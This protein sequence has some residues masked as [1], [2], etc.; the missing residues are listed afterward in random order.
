[1]PHFVTHL[2]HTRHRSAA[3]VRFRR[4]P[5]SMLLGCCLLAAAGCSRDRTQTASDVPI[6][7]AE[8]ADGPVSQ[9]GNIFLVK[10]ETTK[11]DI[12]L[13][14]HRKWAPNGADR[15]QELVESGF[16]DGCRFFRV[17]PNFMA[18]FGING[19]PV[20]QSKWRERTLIDDPVLKSNR[21]GFVT[22]AKTGMPNSRSTQIFINFKDNS[23]LDA[24]GFAPFAEVISGMSTVDAIYAGYGEQPDQGMIQRA[25]N[26][27]LESEFPKLDSIIRATVIA[28]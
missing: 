21:R 13:E 27:Y 12:V 15:F 10:L 18:Q 3:A 22:F 28:Q 7:V 17:V 20:V 23:S 16:Y 6:P 11:G 2:D 24:D 5:L 19:D 4:V 9:Q 14:V 8:A 1:M 25:G 26:A